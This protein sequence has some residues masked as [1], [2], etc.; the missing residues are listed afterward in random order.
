MTRSFEIMLLGLLLLF[1]MLVEATGSPHLPGRPFFLTLLVPTGLIL[2]GALFFPE[3]GRGENDGG[4]VA[5]RSRMKVSA[6][7]AFALTPFFVWQF[8]LYE[9]IYFLVCGFLFLLAFQIYLVALA[10][11]IEVQFALLRRSRLARLARFAGISVAPFMIAVT[12]MIY[13][14]VLQLGEAAAWQPVQS[15]YTVWMRIPSLIQALFGL[16]FLA[17]TILVAVLVFVLPSESSES[18]EEQPERQGQRYR[19]WF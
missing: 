16:P 15:P 17:V 18:A 4:F 12:V 14:H 1:I 2:L 7:T 8:G 9:R 6:L 19:G 11:V 13:F 10:N 3:T 5:N